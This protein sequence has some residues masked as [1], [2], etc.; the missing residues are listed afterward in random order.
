MVL[1]A[2]MG[3]VTTSFLRKNRKYAFLFSFIIAAVVTP[4]PDVVNQTMMA[5]P[6]VVLYEVSILAIRISG[7]KRQKTEDRDQRTDGR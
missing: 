2:K 5:L 7:G 4:T 1:L 6:M 3:L